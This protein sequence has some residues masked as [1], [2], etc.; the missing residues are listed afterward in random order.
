MTNL[1]YVCIINIG[2]E[3]QKCVVTYINV[4]TLHCRPKHNVVSLFIPYLSK[5][6]I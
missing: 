4:K 1:N 5:V 2:N 3:T 6:C